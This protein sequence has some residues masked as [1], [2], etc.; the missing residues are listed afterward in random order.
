MKELTKKI[1][2]SGLVDETTALMMEK[3]GIL[4]AGAADLTKKATLLDATRE[5][6]INFAEEVEEV[7][8]KNRQGRLQE[9]MLD[10]GRLKWPAVCYTVLK[11]EGSDQF[12]FSPKVHVLVDRMGRIYFRPQDVDEGMLVPGRELRVEGTRAGGTIL[13]VT[14]LFIGDEI[15]AI[16][17]SVK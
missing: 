16:Q 9:T 11:R 6:L 3:W 2:E 10:L 13:E 5:Q 1:L 7:V 15:A 12:S 8:E 17:V 4:E 14:E